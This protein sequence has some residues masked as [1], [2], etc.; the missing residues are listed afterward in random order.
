MVRFTFP[1]SSMRAYAARAL[2][3]CVLVAAGCGPQPGAGADA[4][5]L[6]AMRAFGGGGTRPGQFAYPRAIDTDGR[7][8]FVI[9]KEARIQMLDPSDGRCAALW[10]TP[11]WEKG[12][13]TGVTIGPGP[14]GRAAVY[15]PDTH[16]HRVLVYA[17]PEAAAPGAGVDELPAGTLLAQFGSFGT[18]PGE[19][20]FPTDVA[21]V[22]GPDGVVDRIFVSEYGGNDRISVFDA[23]YRFLFAFGGMGT[24]DRPDR[25]EFQRPQSMLIDARAREL[26]VSDA[27]NHRIGRF[28]F[29]GT[30][31]GW[32]GARDASG[33]VGT[34]GREPGSFTIPYGMAWL[35]D[36]TL[37]VAEYGGNRL[38]RLDVRSGRSLGAW[39]TPGRG[40]GNL[41]S[42]WGVAVVGGRTYVLDSRNNRVMV[43]GAPPG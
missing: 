35:D 37:L 26:V 7:W 31:L 25:I 3:P 17:I 36:G 18:G 27:L 32:I 14:G 23:S 43:C 15:V 9:D 6:P 5:P 13:P 16:Y 8:L 22:T 12:K 39:G 11:E 2:I 19:F 28:R 24:S 1:L 33:R 29:D 4:A 40:A 21:V 42:P 38:Q 41:A 30:L 20:Y 10:R 34:P